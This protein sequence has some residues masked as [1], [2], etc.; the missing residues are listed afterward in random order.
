MTL[1]ETSNETPD[2]SGQYVQSLARGLSVIRAFDGDHPEMTLSDLA[3]RTGL[4]RATSRRFLL[5][6]VE[7]GYVKTD[8]RM[9]SLTARVLELGFSYLSALSLPE[10]AQPHLE[11]LAAAI[12]ESTSASVLDGTD[13]VYVARVPTRRIMSV[14]INIGTRFPAFATSMGRVLLASLPAAELDEHLAAID[15]ESRTSHTIGSRA[16]LEKELTRVREQGWA[17]VDQ[18]LENGLRSIA[19]PVRQSD[20]SALAAINVS[21]TASSHT[22]ESIQENLLPPLL[23]AAADISH[24]LTASRPFSRETSRLGGVH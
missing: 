6:L 19:A 18:E 8:G 2:P 1:S 20:G 12:H 4:T 11:Q 7:L 21:T 14:R 22:A 3:R 16:A 5:T 15:Y 9:F 24:D 23:A 13:I 10:I 17:M